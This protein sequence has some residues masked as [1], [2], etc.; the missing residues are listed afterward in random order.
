VAITPG[1]HLR[2]RDLNPW[3]LALAHAGLRAV[4]IREPHLKGAEV[5]ALVMNAWGS[6]PTVVVHERVPRARHFG[7]PVHLSAD[8]DRTQPLSLWSQSCH[9]A[10]QVDAAFDAGAW[11]TCLSPV[12]PPSSKPNDTR[13]PLGIDRLCKIAGSRPVLA[14]GGVNNARLTDLR[15]RGAWGA[16]VMG[17]IFDHPDP[18]SAA[19][20]TEQL[21]RSLQPC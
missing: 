3:L 2:G 10:Q 12:W 6:I 13:D 9:S 20:A 19:R 16:A 14:L 1:D 17:A 8:S 5:D 15:D 11:W 18:S 7:L 21:L 4:I